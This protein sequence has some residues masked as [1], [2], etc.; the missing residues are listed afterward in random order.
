M[1]R[2]RILVVIL[3][4]ILGMT[5]VRVLESMDA[6]PQE[7]ICV[8]AASPWTKETPLL[9]WWGGVYPEYC[10]PGAMKLVE[11]DGTASE[12]KD[13]EIPVKIRFKFLTFFNES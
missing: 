4:L 10:L 3:S 12:S 6:L 8:S 11:G 1:K 7:G 2:E 13:A 9:A 5:G